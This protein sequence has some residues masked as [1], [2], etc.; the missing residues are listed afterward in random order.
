MAI[1]RRFPSKRLCSRL[2]NSLPA[3]F[4]F[5][6]MSKFHSYQSDFFIRRDAVFFYLMNTNNSFISHLLIFRKKQQYLEDKFLT[7][8]RNHNFRKKRYLNF[9]RNRKMS[10]RRKKTKDQVLRWSF[11]RLPLT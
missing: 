9:L 10:L 3:L 5:F 8:K 2:L 4:K 11:N 7:K 1:S 6:E